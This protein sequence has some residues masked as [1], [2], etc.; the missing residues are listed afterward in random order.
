MSEKSKSITN[1]EIHN[2]TI[3][4]H[5]A[6]SHIEKH[7]NLTLEECIECI[8]K[9]DYEKYKELYCIKIDNRLLEH[10]FPLFIKAFYHYIAINESVPGLEEYVNY[11]ID[12]YNEEFL[13]TEDYIYHKGEKFSKNEFYAKI[14]KV[15]PSLVCEYHCSLLIKNLFPKCDVFYS[16]TQDAN[17][18][19]DLMVTNPKDEKVALSLYIDTNI[20]HK[21]HNE[22]KPYK[23]SP[24]IKWCELPHKIENRTAIGGISLYST[25]ELIEKF[26]EKRIFEILCSV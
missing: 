2:N 23:L 5:N 6:D 18:K 7:R 3:N 14:L 1:I 12:F 25:K 20:S 8:S 11:Y 22:K 19:I 16:L 15:Y 10:P 9:S 17:D 13:V 21:I 26:K 4:L 24:A